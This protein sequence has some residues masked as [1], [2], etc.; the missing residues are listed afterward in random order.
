MKVLLS[1][2]NGAVQ[3]QEDA[4]KISLVVSEVAGG[5]N[6]AG[7]VKGSADIVLDAGMGLQLAESLL[8]AHLPA[9]LQAFAPAVEGVVNAA[10]A[11]AE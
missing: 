7:I 3:V 10:V 4:G 6:A 5:G 11:A 1:L 2:Q 9:A 8:N